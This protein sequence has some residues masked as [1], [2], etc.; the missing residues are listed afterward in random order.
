MAATHSTELLQKFDD[1]RDEILRKLQSDLGTL[2]A[3]IVSEMDSQ[4]S[5]SHR[6]TQLG[7]PSKMTGRKMSLANVISNRMSNFATEFYKN[8]EQEFKRQFSMLGSS[9]IATNSTVG[10]IADGPDPGNS[11]GSVALGQ[12]AV[13]NNARGEFELGVRVSE[14]AP[15]SLA[16]GPPARLPGRLITYI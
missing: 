10:G 6:Q 14:D 16:G 1:F 7:R 9:R 5:G 3:D 8:L 13:S 2:R 12:T 15:S 4:A 11:G